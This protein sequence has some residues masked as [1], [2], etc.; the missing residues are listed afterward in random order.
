MTSLESYR[1]E[2]AESALKF[3]AAY[4]FDG[5]D[6]DW[7]YPTERGGIDEDRDNFIELLKYTRQRFD[8][9]GLLLTI[10]VP[11]SVDYASKSYAMEKLNE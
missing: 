6:I 3:L 7:E 10:A 5:L 11:L 2:F 1:K 8:K 9:W 4:D